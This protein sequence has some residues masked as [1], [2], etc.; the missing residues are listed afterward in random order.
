M[1]GFQPE[2]IGNTQQEEE[3]L[4]TSNLQKHELYEL[5]SSKYMLP[6]FCSRGVTRD[7][8][9]DVKKDKVFRVET[10]Q[11]KHFEIN[12][13][14]EHFKKVGISNNAQLMKKLNILLIIDGKNPLGFNQYEVPDQNWLYKIARYIDTTNIMEFFEIAVTPPPPLTPESHLIYKINYGRLF[15]C[16]WLFRLACTKNNKKLWESLKMLSEV[17]RTLQSHRLNVEL[18]EHE[19]K[20]TR[21]KVIYYDATLLDL[22]SKA[23]FTY[24]SLENPSIKPEL[25]ISGGEQFTPEMR[26]ILNN[27]ARL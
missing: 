22:T 21:E 13:T 23:A 8:L 20:Q 26:D 27:N 24:T 3:D 17:H 14:K 2:L 7:Y 11:Y 9:I 25:V 15:A 6:P 10:M 5:V 19:L 1:L 4:D 18:L 16:Q 12:L